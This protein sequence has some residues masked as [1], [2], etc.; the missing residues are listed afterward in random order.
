MSVDLSKKKKKRKI[1]V[2]SGFISIR[3]QFGLNFWS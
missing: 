3:I 2:S 1:K